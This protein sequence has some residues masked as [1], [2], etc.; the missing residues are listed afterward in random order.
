MSRLARFSLIV[1]SVLCGPVSAATPANGLI[2]LQDSGQTVPVAGYLAPMAGAL[3]EEAAQGGPDA[4]AELTVFPVRT[5]SMRAGQAEARAPLKM[6]GRLAQPLALMGSDPYSIAWLKRRV[7]WLNAQSAAIQ[8]VEV[9]DLATYT[10]IR[11]I[12]GALP[13]LPA[14]ADALAGQYGLTTYPI[15]ILPNGG[16]AQ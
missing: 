4:P 5:A 15:V 6:P 1:A 11:R 7:T 10:Q 12:A 3:V 13:V 9:P 16:L 14:S 8:L 2:V